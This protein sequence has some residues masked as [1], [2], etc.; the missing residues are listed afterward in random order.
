[1]PG[2]RPV[3]PTDEEEPVD[4]ATGLEIAEDEETLPLAKKTPPK[5]HLVVIGERREHVETFDSV[6]DF[7]EA[8][9]KNK[10]DKSVT[11][12]YAFFGHRLRG[13]L[14]FTTGIQLTCDDETVAIAEKVSSSEEIFDRQ[15]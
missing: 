12:M 4:G 2:D 13:Q 10:G 15:E 7:T 9:A 8:L 1:M 5:Y 11:G 6:R 14:T 3:P